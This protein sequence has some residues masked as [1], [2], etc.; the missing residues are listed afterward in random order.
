MHEGPTSPQAA[1]H[2]L[3]SQAGGA[4]VPPLHQTYAQ[5]RRFSASRGETARPRRTELQSSSWREIRVQRI[6]ESARPADLDR[7]EDIDLD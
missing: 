4:R 6:A 1:H 7:S 3:V 2:A 5:L